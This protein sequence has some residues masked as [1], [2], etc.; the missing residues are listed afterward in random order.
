MKGF[1]TPASSKD[2]KN[3]I[4]DGYRIHVGSSPKQVAA[5]V[6]GDA[7]SSHVFYRACTEGIGA[8]VAGLS[9]AHFYEV[10]K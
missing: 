2:A 6:N 5:M 3:R 8:L 4:A 10:G 9:G 7:A 1:Q